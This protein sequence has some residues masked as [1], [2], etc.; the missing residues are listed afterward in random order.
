M[1]GLEEVLGALEII[2]LADVL[3][4]LDGISETLG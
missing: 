3:G 1:D 2:G 4:K